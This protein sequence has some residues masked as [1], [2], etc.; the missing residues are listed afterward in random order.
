MRELTQQERAF[1]LIESKRYLAK[2]GVGYPW[3]CLGAFI[4]YEL[5]NDNTLWANF[6]NGCFCVYDFV[7]DTYYSMYKHHKDPIIAT[8]E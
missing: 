1:G 6:E 7:I 3:Y 8:D 4:E 5:Q 2:D